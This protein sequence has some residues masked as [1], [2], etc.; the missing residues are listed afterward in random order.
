MPYTSKY[1]GPDLTPEEIDVRASLRRY[2][3]AG[4]SEFDWVPVAILYRAYRNWCALHRWQLDFDAPQ[5]LT[6]RQFGRA[7]RRGFKTTRPGKRSYFGKPFVLV[8]NLLPFAR[9]VKSSRTYKRNNEHQIFE[10]HTAL[11]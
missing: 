10:H 11:H 9:S 6:V 7:V 5:K 4:A 2:S 8:T 1:N 3:T